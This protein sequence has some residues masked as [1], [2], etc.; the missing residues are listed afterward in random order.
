MI[1]YQRDWNGNAPIPFT[2]ISVWTNEE[3]SHYWVANWTNKALIRPLFADIY[4][5][6]NLAEAI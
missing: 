4:L 3:Q 1:F 6:L 2:Y 5:Y